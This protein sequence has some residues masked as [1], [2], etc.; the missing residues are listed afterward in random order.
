MSENQ[1]PS[2]SITAECAA[3]E[4]GDLRGGRVNILNKQH[5]V[6]LLAVYELVDKFL[7]Q[8]K[9]EATRPKTFSFSNGDVA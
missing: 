9:P 8:Q 2:M 6:A 5:L 1:R 4:L 3:P 7:C